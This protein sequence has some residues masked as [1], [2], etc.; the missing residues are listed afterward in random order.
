ML[1]RELRS[2][3]DLGVRVHNAESRALN[4]VREHLHYFNPLLHANARRFNFALKA[5]AELSILCDVAISHSRDAAT[6]EAYRN[7]ASYLWSE[8]FCKAALQD[9]LLTGEVGLLTAGIYGSLRQCGYEDEE[10]RFRLSQLLQEGYIS[11]VERLPHRELDY[12]YSLWRAGF[13]SSEKLIKDTYRR[14]LLA[15]HPRLYPL[16]TDDVYGITHVIFFVTG[17]GLIE[18]SCFT[19]DDLNYFR[20]ALP[21]LLQFYLRK[22]NW[23]LASELLIT[24]Q[25]TKVQ[26]GPVYE[27]AWVVLSSSQLADGSYSASSSGNNEEASEERNDDDDDDDNDTN[28]PTEFSS[29]MPDWATFR[30]NYHTTLLMLTVSLALR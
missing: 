11:A 3:S 28:G 21:R 29:S 7:L 16:T 15:Q 23:D 5:V 12:I 8:V 17:F 19:V 1:R 22:G 13:P 2:R 6:T 10:Y 20:F 25:D 18:P 30:D 14:T 27:D 24:I 9:H 26:A 4:W